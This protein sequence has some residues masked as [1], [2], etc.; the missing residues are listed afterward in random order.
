VRAFGDRLRTK[1]SGVLDARALGYLERMEGATARMQALIEDLLALSRVT[2][3]GRP[4]APVDLL[5]EVLRGVLSDLEARVEQAGGRVEVGG[6]PSVEADR[7]QMRQL[8]Q[9]L[10]SNALKFSREGEPPVVRVRGEPSDGGAVWRI[11]VEDNGIGFEGEYA[12]RIFA[13]FE[14]RHGRGAYEGT[15]M[16]LA[17]CRRVVERHGGT[18]TARSAPG[19]GAT[20]AVTLPTKQ[21]EA[22]EGED[23]EKNGQDTLPRL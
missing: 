20:F 5:G 23:R 4:F 6:L 12:E 14:R 11:V 8:F 2:T 1:Y 13:P 18:I 3:K 21:P 7:A 17:I 15:G 9:N 10:V 22:G 19:R 16:G